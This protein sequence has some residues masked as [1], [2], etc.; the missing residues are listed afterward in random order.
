MIKYWPQNTRLFILS[1]L[2]LVTMVLC[3]TALFL[4]YWFIVD[5]HYTKSNEPVKVYVPTIKTTTKIVATTVQTTTNTTAPVIGRKKRSAEWNLLHALLPT[6][7]HLRYKRQL[8]KL[9]QTFNNL[10]VPEVNVGLFYLEYP[11]ADF[12]TLTELKYKLVSLIHLENTAPVLVVPSKYLFCCVFH[13]K[14]IL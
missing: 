12:R 11:Y 2:M 7:I 6:Q 9:G 10:R 5:F 4:P 13:K 8:T 3:L 1:N 14:A